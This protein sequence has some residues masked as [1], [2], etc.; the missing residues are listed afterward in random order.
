MK[1]ANWSKDFTKQFM[2]ERSLHHKL[3]IILLVYIKINWFWL[4]RLRN[5]IKIRI[6]CFGII[7]GWALAYIIEYTLPS[8]RKWLCS[9]VQHV[10]HNVW[11]KHP[12]YPKLWYI[13]VVKSLI[14]WKIHWA[15]GFKCNA[16]L[17]PNNFLIHSLFKNLLVCALNSV[18]L[19][20]IVI[21]RR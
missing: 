11:N 14:R 15:V 9:L 8:Q 21:L 20:L 12:V 18:Y 3:A 16:P 6:H 1:S 2:K 19:L 17:L 7:D 10:Y 13:D 5:N 4:V